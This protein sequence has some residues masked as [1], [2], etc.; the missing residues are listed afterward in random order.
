MGHYLRVLCV[1]LGRLFPI[2]PLSLVHLA[3]WYS[4][5][6]THAAP[7]VIHPGQSLCDSDLLSPQQLS[8]PQMILFVS[9]MSAGSMFVLINARGI[10]SVH[11]LWI[12]VHHFH[13]PKP[14]NVLSVVPFAISPE[15]H[16]VQVS[17]D[18]LI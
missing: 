9:S 2:L 4:G 14:L 13:L 18:G 10:Q 12:L 11:E 16:V 3:P 17:Q 7:L 1:P 6:S 5:L 15:L 8:L